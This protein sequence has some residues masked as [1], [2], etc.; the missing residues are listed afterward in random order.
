MRDE[1]RKEERERMR[2][3]AGARC[4]GESERGLE[5]VSGRGGIHLYIF[6]AVYIPRSA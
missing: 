2:A 1:E 6:D 5:V 3:D 4:I